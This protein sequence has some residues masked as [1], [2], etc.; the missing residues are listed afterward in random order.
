LTLGAFG[1]TATSFNT[2]T[3]R[4]RSRLNPTYSNTADTIQSQIDFK[5]DGKLPAEVTLGFTFRHKSKWLVGFDVSFADWSS[6]EN[7]AGDFNTENSIKLNK[8]S[9]FSGGFQ[10]TPDA[11]SYNKYL[12][13]VSYRFGGYFFDDPR[14]DDLKTYAL[15][16]GAGFPI[17]LSRNRTSFVNLAFEMGNTNS[18]TIDE[19]FYRVNVGFTLNDN[20]WFFKRKFN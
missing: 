10:I 14:L 9:R 7:P 15:T 18:D 4:L 2:S 1:H 3:T 19:R 6:Y 8:S 5:Q 13:R 11:A 17:I 12:K 16:V 20:S